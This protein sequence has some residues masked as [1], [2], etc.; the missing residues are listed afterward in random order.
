MTRADCPAWVEDALWAAARAQLEPGVLA[1]PAL[2]DAVVDRSRRYTSEREHLRDDSPG[3]LAARA[4]FFTVADAAKVLVPLGELAAARGLPVDRPVRAIDVGAGVGAMSFGAAAMLADGPGLHVRAID[5]DAA[6]LRLLRAAFDA[7]G[8]DAGPS[9]LDV[10]VGDVRDWQH[11]GEPVDLVIAGTV[12][13]ELD[14]SERE[15][16]VRRWLEWIRPDGAVVILEP[17]LRETARDLHAVRDAVLAAGAARAFAPCVRQGPCPALDDESDWCHEDR[18]TELPPR[19]RALAQ[20]TG[21]RDA[22]LKFSYLVLRRDDLAQVATER[23]AVRVVSQPKR[24]KGKLELYGCGE[25]GRTLMRLLKRN[26]AEVNRAFER[27]RRG[28]VLLVD[29]DGDDIGADTAVDR[30]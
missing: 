9:R 11:R 14:P 27:A 1:R 5:R 18:L 26:R 21:L 7:A 3:D 17:A 25:H 20:A 8:R 15:P 16:L 28:D 19:T 24:S 30:A 10:E 22:G 2:V 12:L 29:A 23:R 4:L 13:N 6:A